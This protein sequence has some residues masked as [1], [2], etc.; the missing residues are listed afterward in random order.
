[1]AAN[2]LSAVLTNNAAAILMYKI[3]MNTVDQ[4]PGLDRKKMALVL[5]LAASDYMT[6]FGYQ[7]N[8]M[9]YGP[10]GY[11]NFDFMKFGAPMQLLLWLTTTAMVAA[12]DD[13]VY[14]WWIMS[15]LGLVAASA[16]RL[17]GGEIMLRRIRAR[18]L[19]RKNHEGDDNDVDEDIA[20][21]AS[22]PEVHV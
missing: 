18:A 3:A 13:M 7:T 5:M 1:L 11:S 2:L 10:G 9:V 19:K 12:P 14:I 21:V 16:M 22:V 8:L 6:S 15:V 17:V 4:S 20:M